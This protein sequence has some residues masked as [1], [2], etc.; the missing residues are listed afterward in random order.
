[1]EWF[2]NGCLV[3]NLPRRQ[4]TVPSVLLSCVSHDEGLVFGKR[5]GST[6]T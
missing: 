6:F 1:L 2:A 3:M 5:D 4:P